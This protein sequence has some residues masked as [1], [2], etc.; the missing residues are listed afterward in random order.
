MLLG[1]CEYS[2]LLNI[3][4][5]ITIFD[6]ETSNIFQVF[7]NLKTVCFN[8]IGYMKLGLVENEK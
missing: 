6:S 4:V 7:L 1:V 8:E 5:K 3:K 2:K